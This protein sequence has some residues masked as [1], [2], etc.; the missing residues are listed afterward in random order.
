[1]G[2]DS[3]TD[4]RTTALSTPMNVFWRVHPPLQPYFE[5]NVE[6]TDE[7]QETGICGLSVET[8]SQ[9]FLVVEAETIAP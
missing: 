3:T 2:V 9:L 7:K 6:F 1:M 4:K 8:R 5:S